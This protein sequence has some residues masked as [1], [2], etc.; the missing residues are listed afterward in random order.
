VEGIEVSRHCVV[1]RAK[2]RT[3]RLRGTPRV[4]RCFLAKSGALAYLREL[5]ARG[6]GSRG[7]SIK[8]VR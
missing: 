3:G 1:S 8:K 6:Y 5:K 7:L 2:V 4:W